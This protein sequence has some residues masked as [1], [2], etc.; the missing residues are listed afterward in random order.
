MVIRTNSCVLLNSDPS[1]KGST[2]PFSH[3]QI[4]LLDCFRCST[5]TEVNTCGPHNALQLIPL[6]L[7]FEVNLVLS[8]VAVD[9]ELVA[10]L[11]EFGRRAV[12][13]DDQGGL[14]CSSHPDF[15]T[16][17]AEEFPAHREVQ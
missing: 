9:V 5:F 8:A 13:I 12:E 11:G 16:F 17:F 15:N 6:I 7:E 14:E 3:N 2:G 1:P 4:N 10:P